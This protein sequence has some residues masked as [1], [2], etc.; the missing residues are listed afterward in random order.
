M[1]RPWGMIYFQHYILIS[2]YKMTHTDFLT[3][4]VRALEKVIGLLL[5]SINIICLSTLQDETV[6]YLEELI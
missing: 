6:C 2:P 3:N 5:K 1:Q 4:A